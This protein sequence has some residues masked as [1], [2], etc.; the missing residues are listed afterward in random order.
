MNV[1]YLNNYSGDELGGGE[2]HLLSLLRAMGDR[3]SPVIGV[4]GG[5]AIERR[6]AEEGYDARPVP[7]ENAPSAIAEIARLAREQGAAL[8][9]AHGYYPGILARFASERSGV[10]A[11][12][13]MHCVPDVILESGDTPLRRLAVWARGRVDNATAARVCRVIAVSEVVREGLLEQGFPAEKIVVIDNGVDTEAV[14]ERAAAGSRLLSGTGDV[15]W[16]GTAARM[17]GGKRLDQLLRA[18]PLLPADVALAVG[19]GGPL[20]D[21]LRALAE[22]LGVVDRVRFLGHLDNVPAFASEVRVFVVSS[23]L[24]GKNLTMLE[25]M[26]VGTPVVGTR[27]GAG[28][29]IVDGESG[30]LVESGSPAEIAEAVSRVLA[31]PALA[32]RLSE[33]GRRQAEGRFGIAAQMDATWRVY[34]ECSATRRGETG[35][36]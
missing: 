32:S 23:P 11:I 36:E 15:R 24:G 21:D 7:Y 10:P 30:L 19:G 1:L 22:E 25:A 12:S 18:V 33:G 2:T 34:E 27:G 31:D 6:L 35:E 5:S 16:I 28:E 3:V 13:T 29:A 8:I 9:H 26:A 14:V 17:E 20:A 4:V